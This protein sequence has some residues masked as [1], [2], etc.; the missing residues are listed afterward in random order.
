MSRPDSNGEI[1]QNM[2]S[3]CV[4][5]VVRERACTRLFTPSMTVKDEIEDDDSL[6]LLRM[7]SL[8]LQPMFQ[9]EKKG[10]VVGSVS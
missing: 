10:E 9:L 5:R 7:E 8:K 6:L 4:R 3:R 2:A 1:L